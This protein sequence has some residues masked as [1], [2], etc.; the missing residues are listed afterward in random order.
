LSPYEDRKGPESKVK[1]SKITTKAEITC[2]VM[3]LASEADEFTECLLIIDLRC[4]K[5][6]LKGARVGCKPFKGAKVRNRIVRKIKRE[7]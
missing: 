1:K 2:Q 4:A 7:V 5:V 6:R 3:Q